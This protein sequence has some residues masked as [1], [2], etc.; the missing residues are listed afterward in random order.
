MANQQKKAPRRGDDELDAAFDKLEQEAPDFLTRA[1]CWLRKPQ[2]RMVRLPLGILFIAA[3]FFWFLPVLGL[4]FL[5]IGLLL[6]AQDVPFLRRPVGR[7]TLWLLDRWVQLR[8][9]WTRR[10]A[11]AKARKQRAQPHGR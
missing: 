7:M 6:V 9:W 1:I 5:P 2:A 4:E 3:S 8:K 11:A 10:R